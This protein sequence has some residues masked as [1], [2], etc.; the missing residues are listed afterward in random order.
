MI[1]KL[2]RWVLRLL[3]LKL[4]DVLLHGQSRMAHIRCWRLCETLC[5]GKQGWERIVE[6]IHDGRRRRLDDSVLRSGG[7]QMIFRI[8]NDQLYILELT[9]ELKPHR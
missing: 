1:A 7:G 9:L 2:R 8:G 5:I 3:Y 4:R 6:V